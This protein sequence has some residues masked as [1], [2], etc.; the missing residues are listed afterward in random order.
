M[1]LFIFVMVVIFVAYL[2]LSRNNLEN[3]TREVPKGDDFDGRSI[4]SIFL[5]EEIIDPDAGN[6]GVAKQDFGQIE[7]LEDDFFEEEF[8]D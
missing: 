1:G 8:F 5:L 4:S 2:F 7:E 3:H 6:H